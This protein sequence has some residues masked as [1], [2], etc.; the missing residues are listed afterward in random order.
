ME[1]HLPLLYFRKA[2]CDPE[3]W[4]ISTTQERILQFLHIRLCAG[5]GQVCRNMTCGAS[6]PITAKAGYRDPRGR[7]P[8]QMCPG[9]ER[10]KAPM[11]SMTHLNDCMWNVS[12]CAFTCVC[13][14]EYTAAT[15]ERGSLGSHNSPQCH[16][17][18]KKW[19]HSWKWVSAP[20]SMGGLPNFMPSR[21]LL[22]F[23]SLGRASGSTVNGRHVQ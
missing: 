13:V 20:S 7:T 8:Q 9:S 2:V 6:L 18:S 4:G 11:F 16:S 23:S 14:C 1:L 5:H 12:L 10:S 17:G 19:G 22:F 15:N 21:F 3:C